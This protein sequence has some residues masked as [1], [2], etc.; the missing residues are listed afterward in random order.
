MSAAKRVAMVKAATGRAGKEAG[1]GSTRQTGLKGGAV[2]KVS[3]VEGAKGS[4]VQ[5]KDKGSAVQKKDKGST[6][7]KEVEE[8][9]K[10]V[11]SEVGGWLF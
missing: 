11:E 9:E 5:K 3:G 10:A 7:R 6:A 2:G 4:V 8:V 1:K